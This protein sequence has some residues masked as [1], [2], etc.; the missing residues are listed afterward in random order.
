MAGKR[1]ESIKECPRCGLKLIST[2][3]PEICDWRL[4]CPGPKCDY[5]ENEPIDA[6]LRREGHV[7]FPGF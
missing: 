5:N 3:Y 4:G 2:Y 6:Q 7:A 1:G